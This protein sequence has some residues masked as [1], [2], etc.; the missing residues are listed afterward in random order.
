MPAHKRQKSLIRL[1]KEPEDINPPLEE[2]DKP[3]VEEPLDSE[4]DSDEED[5]VASLGS[6]IPAGYVVGP[7][8]SEVQLEFRSE[9]SHGA[10][11]QTQPL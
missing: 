10:G 5:A 9:E 1:R 7:P 3:G 6:A 8:P 4:D 11:G 2:E